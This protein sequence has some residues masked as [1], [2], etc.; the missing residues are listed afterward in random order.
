MKHQPSMRLAAALGLALC[1]CSSPMKNN[2][3]VAQT[4]KQPMF[5]PHSLADDWSRWMVGEWEGT[6]ESNTGQGTG[7]ERI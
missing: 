6:G 5:F 3:S 7:I 4:V 1:S 2:S